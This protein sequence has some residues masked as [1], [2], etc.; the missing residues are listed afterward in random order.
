MNESPRPGQSGGPGRRVLLAMGV[1]VLLA[2]LALLSGVGGL[3]PVLQPAANPVLQP[4][5][6]RVIEPAAPAAVTAPVTTPAATASPHVRASARLLADSAPPS[7]GPANP[8]LSAPAQEPEDSAPIPLAA[9]SE[10]G[11]PGS[12]MPTTGRTDPQSGAPT[13]LAG[14]PAA[15]EPSRTDL[16][17]AP[18]PPTGAA[19]PS[20]QPQARPDSARQPDAAPSI[21]TASGA[22][23]LP[24]TSPPPTP[25]PVAARSEM[26]TTTVQ[27]LPP[28]SA[29]AKGAEAGTAA[30]SVSALAV[31]RAQLPPSLVMDYAMNGMDRGLT[32]H[33]SGQLRW[34]H[35]E[36]RYTL[37]LTVR[38]LLLGNREWRSQGLIGPQGLQPQRFSDKRRTERAT[39]FDREG[40]R[41]VFSGSAAPVPLL[42]GAQDQIS[43]YVQMAAAIASATPPMPEGTRLQVQTAT[44]RDALPWLLTLERHETLRFEGQALDTAYWVCLPRQRFDARIELWT[45]PLHHHLPA[46]IRITQASGSF[47]DL[48]LRNLQTLAPLPA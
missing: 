21:S 11:N 1:A 7:D 8:P 27:A 33:A 17:G 20:G 28:G 5:Q 24:G 37:S 43:L 3:T 19:T 12:T 6:T 22:A 31:D 35:N 46:R 10:A 30:G 41:V 36:E 14:T 47:I 25:A 13:D 34:Q 48:Q 15:S 44:S 29:P 4:L 32:Y 9:A 18:T 38:A 23:S 26:A 42:S 2:H 39:H 40:G 16:A 45:S